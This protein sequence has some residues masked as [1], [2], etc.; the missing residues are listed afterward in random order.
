MATAYARGTIALRKQSTRCLARHDEVGADIVAGDGFRL[1]SACSFLARGLV[2]PPAKWLHRR[3]V[4]VDAPAS[5][6]LERSRS[7]RSS[8]PDFTTLAEDWIGYLAETSGVDFDACYARWIAS[9]NRQLGRVTD[10]A[11][12][13]SSGRGAAGDRR[14]MST[15]ALFGPDAHHDR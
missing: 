3:L 5:E 13:P 12:P 4:D 15:R 2:P 7:T 11:V 10:A 14:A 8:S 1:L 6:M 9:S